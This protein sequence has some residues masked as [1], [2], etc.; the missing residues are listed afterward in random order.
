MSLAD[1]LRGMP[2]GSL[3]PVDWVLGQLATKPEPPSPTPAT[4]A[5]DRLLDV[6]EAAER[7]GVS[8]RWMYR[9]A[10]ALPFTRRL[11]AGTLRFSS[12]GLERW[13]QRQTRG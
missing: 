12:A 8:K 6:G 9:R 13:Q 11:S 1:V 7:L 4:D 3:V 2:P 10:A 5:A